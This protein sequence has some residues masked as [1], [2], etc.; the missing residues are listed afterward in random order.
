VC[1][2]REDGRVGGDADIADCPVVREVNQRALDFLGH[3]FDDS[4]CIG[5]LLSH[6]DWLAWSDEMV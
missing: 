5:V 2:F 3:A 6:D 1:R 4:E